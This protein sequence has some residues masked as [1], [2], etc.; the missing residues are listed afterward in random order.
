MIDFAAIASSAQQTNAATQAV[1]ET[2]AIVVGAIVVSGGGY[3]FSKTV[4]GL[5]DM[6]EVKLILVGKDPTEFDPE[7]EDGMIKTVRKH[8]EW[9][10][11]LMAA[12]KASLTDNTNVQGPT[13]REAL[14][15]L[16]QVETTERNG[17]S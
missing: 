9:L 7:G 5:K 11:V 4:K 14:R 1:V 16:T 13:S 2:I 8:G 17:H 10:K 3:L 12:S 15:Q 6:H